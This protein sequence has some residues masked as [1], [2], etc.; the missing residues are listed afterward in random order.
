MD[1]VLLYIVASF[2]LVCGFL[3][4]RRYPIIFV[5]LGMLGCLMWAIALK[6]KKKKEVCE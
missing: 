6:V 1:R 2:G 4:S 5:V 3:F